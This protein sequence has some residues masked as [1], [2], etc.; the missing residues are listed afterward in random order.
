MHMTKVRKCYIKT[1]T[2]KFVLH[3]NVVNNV[4]FLYKLCYNNFES[5]SYKASGQYYSNETVKIWN[6]YMQLVTLKKN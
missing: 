4:A 5:Q 2:L 3:H 1:V 6:Q